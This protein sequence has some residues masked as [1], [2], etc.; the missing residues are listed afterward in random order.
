MRLKV[1]QWG[2]SLRAIGTNLFLWEGPDVVPGGP[3]PWVGS[4]ASQ[5]PGLSPAAKLRWTGK[6]KKDKQAAASE[7]EMPVWVWIVI[8][9][10][11]FLGLSLLVCFALPASLGPIG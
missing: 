10:S 4:E 2:K 9:V 1:P 3:Q 8:G 11:S 7:V 6:R 5:L